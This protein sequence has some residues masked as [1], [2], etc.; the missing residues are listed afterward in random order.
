MKIGRYICPLARGR[1]NS[2]GLL[3]ALQAHPVPIDRAAYDG[4]PP[5]GPG[6]DPAY[7][8]TDASSPAQ[9][10]A[11]PPVD[12]Y[13]NESRPLHR[14]STLR[15]CQCRAAAPP[16]SSVAPSGLQ[17][18]KSPAAPLHAALLVSLCR[19]PFPPR[20]S[21]FYPAPALPPVRAHRRLQLNVSAH[22]NDGD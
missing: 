3:L 15:V 16:S 8:R 7:S 14:K 11:R 4:P 1:Q 19:S 21:P 12:D 10:V 5:T 20:G 17:T 6:A 13:K 9:P 22:P 18:K 2:A